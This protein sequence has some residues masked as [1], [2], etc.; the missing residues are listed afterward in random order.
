MQASKA[1]IKKIKIV[2]KKVQS[3]KVQNAAII[4]YNIKKIPTKKREKIIQ[5][6]R[7]KI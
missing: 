4:Q 5:K 3:T 2:T 6:K 1:A 7:K